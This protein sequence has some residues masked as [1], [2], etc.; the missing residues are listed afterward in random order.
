MGEV[1]LSDNLAPESTIADAAKLLLQA[2]EAGYAF[3]LCQV[4]L[5]QQQLFNYLVNLGGS[6]GDILVLLEQKLTADAD[7]AILERNKLINHATKDDLEELRS[8][9]GEIFIYSRFFQ[10]PK[11]RVLDVGGMYLAWLEELLA[12]QAEIAVLK[13]ASLE[14][15]I[16]LEAVNQDVAKIGLLAVKQSARGR[17]AGVA[18]VNWSIQQAIQKGFK[19]IQVGTQL[20]NLPA[21]RLY[22]KTGF[23]IQATKYRVH[24]WLEQLD[25]KQLEAEW[26]E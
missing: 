26:I 2:R 3:L 4:P 23:Q 18:L 15:F 16:T 8:L 22:E 25:W 1:R 14:G 7:S 11:F 17:G 19:S 9:V 13:T 6:L 24:L 12:S 20:M 10:D 5:S 21:V